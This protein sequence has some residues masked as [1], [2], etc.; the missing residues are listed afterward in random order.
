MHIAPE[1]AKPAAHQISGL[2]SGDYDKNYDY[3][4]NERAEAILNAVRVNIDNVRA[5]I[6][7]QFGIGREGEVAAIQ[8]N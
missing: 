7:K 3:F 1:P 4:L 6:L 2:L 5:G 8:R